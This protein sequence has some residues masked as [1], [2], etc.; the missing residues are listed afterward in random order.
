MKGSD[1]SPF[2]RLGCIVWQLVLLVG[3]MSFSTS[4]ST[5]S[6]G[7]FYEEKSANVILEFYGWEAIYMTRPDTRQDGYLPLLS[8]AQV[9]HELGNRVMPHDLAVVVIGNT[10][11]ATQVPQLAGEWKQLLGERGFRRVVFLRAGTGKRI[12]GLPIIEDSIISSADDPHGRPCTLVT[13]P[14]ATEAGSIR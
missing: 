4:C 12:N 7:R 10:Y 9:E 13:M 14:T 2:S 6:L 3:L 5:V 1:R 8:R 11:S